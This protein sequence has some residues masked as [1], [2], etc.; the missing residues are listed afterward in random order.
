MTKRRHQPRGWDDV[1]DWYDGWMGKN[2]SWHHQELAIPLLMNL[3][4]IKSGD[5]VLDVGCGQGVLFPHIIESNCDYVGIDVSRKMIQH[6][7]Q[8]HGT[9]GVFVQ[10]DAANLSSISDLQPQESFD[11]VVF[12]LS[13]QDMDP[14]DRIIEQTAKMIKFGGHIVIVMKHP[15]FRIPRQSGWGFD[16]I[17]K[18]QYRRVDHYLDPLP[19]PV[20]QHGKGATITFHR[21]LQTYIKALSSVNLL[22]DKMYEVPVGEKSMK[23]K[24]AKAELRAENQIPLFM[25]LRAIKVRQ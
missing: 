8:H 4:D 15:A 2:G 12:L 1:A 23:K 24:R 25:G 10:G 14:L 7:K 16:D 21:P 6:A 11:H 18:I 20:K 19:I 22:I 13:I 5:R 17:R 9:R 3:L